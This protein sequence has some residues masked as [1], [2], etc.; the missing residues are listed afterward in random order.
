MER[1]DRISA[2][3]L[4]DEADSDYIRGVVAA[5][6][7]EHL[8]VVAVSDP[9]S[10]IPAV[11]ENT[12]SVLILD[13]R[14]AAAREVAR[15]ALRSKP[16]LAV[17]FWTAFAADEDFRDIE[18]SLNPV[19]RCAK[20]SKLADAPFAPTAL[21]RSLVDPVRSLHRRPTVAPLPK[22]EFPPTT[23]SSAFR[24]G[25]DDFERL[26]FESARKLVREVR[27]QS[28][29]IVTHVFQ[30]SSAEWLLIAGPN[31]D[32]IRWG[33]TLG[34]MPDTVRIKE[35]GNRYKYVPFL[36][37]RPVIADDLELAGHTSWA[38][39]PPGE[40]YPSLGID[41][42]D[43]EGPT[44]QIHFDTG[45]PKTLLSCAMLVDS[46]VIDEPGPLDIRPGVRLP[47]GEFEWID[48]VISV[49]LNDGSDSRRIKMRP[50]IILDWDESPFM[51]VCPHGECPGSD[52]SQAGWLCGRRLSG[53][54]GRDVLM[55]G[56]ALVLD[57]G[58]RTTRFV[59]KA[60]GTRPRP[61]WPWT[62]R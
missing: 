62:E 9:D 7:A 21:R 39:C 45:T 52:K 19:T 27:E 24:M 13:M 23:L 6:A 43:E 60:E 35:L 33:A 26:S 15:D 58:T 47:F 34:N 38:E 56:I 55:E 46:G 51:R 2:V 61:R 11:R 8:D 20:G 37:T 17:Y 25:V 5:S 31:M 42:V 28:K 29:A 57:G 40:Y 41:F 22:E 53:L 12:A 1:D 18:T 48:R 4:D 36:F 44:R 50:L 54:L 59:R 14:G 16:T 49:L 32:V 10:V 3:L 30:N